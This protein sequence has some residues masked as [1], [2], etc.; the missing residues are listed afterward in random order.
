MPFSFHSITLLLFIISVYLVIRLY[1]ANQYLKSEVKRRLEIENHLSLVMDS[2]SDGVVVA[3][4]NG[5]LVLFNAMANKVVGLGMQ[6]VLPDQWT[7]TY[8]LFLPDGKTPFKMDDLPLYRAIKGEKSTGVE[9]FI[10]NK[11]H[12]DGIFI[13]VDSSPIYAN[14]KLDGAVSIVRD[15]THQRKQ[16]GMLKE[17]ERKLRL[18]L[19][20]VAGI[21]WSVDLNLMITSSY[22]AGLSKLNLKPEELVGVSLY[23]YMRS[24]DPEYLPIKAHLNAIKGESSQYDFEWMGTVFETYVE[25][26]VDFSGNPIGAIGLCVDITKKVRAEQERYK[27]EEQNRALLDA[28]PDL[29]FRIDKEGVYLDCKAPKDIPLLTPVENLIGRNFNTIVPPELAGRTAEAMDKAFKTGSVQSF[30]YQ[31]PFNESIYFFEARIVPCAP[32]EVVAIIR[33]ITQKK[34]LEKEILEISDRVQERIGRDLHDG[35]GQNLTGIAL[36]CKGLSQILQGEGNPQSK[37]AAEIAQLVNESIAQCRSLSRGLYPVE[38]K[39]N[40]LLPAL[41]ELVFR[42]QNYYGISCKLLVDSS[43][44]IPATDFALHLYRIIQEAINN[45]IRHG[46]AQHISITLGKKDQLIRLEIQDDGKGFCSEGAGDGMGLNIMR[47]R[48]SV[49]GAELS[50]HSLKNEGTSV[51]CTFQI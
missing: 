22:G 31:L 42:C 5:R 13:N 35:L 49:I 51:I 2:M 29:M 44:V 48:A 46:E 12:P 34:I 45:A 41:E 30:E 25:Q 11:D 9:M 36:M 4:K 14:A 16:D 3:D 43:I 7:E 18:L 15:I 37:T 21:V 8:G 10:R 28:I 33:N 38:L 40:G 1:F 26:L 50:F 20:K 24:K 17:N 47:Y 32:T 19:D 27:T 6:D 23:D 39:E